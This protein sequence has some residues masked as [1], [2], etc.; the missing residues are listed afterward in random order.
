MW[1]LGPAQGKLQLL[2]GFPNTRPND[3]EQNKDNASLKEKTIR[4]FLLRLG[5]HGNLLQH[6]VSL[7]EQPW[8]QQR[9]QPQ[10]DTVNRMML[11]DSPAEPCAASVVTGPGKA[12]MDT[13]GKAKFC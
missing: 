11:T 5:V 10:T 2:L 7:T 4:F 13:A 6:W 12:T 8:L 3:T 1:A 9:S